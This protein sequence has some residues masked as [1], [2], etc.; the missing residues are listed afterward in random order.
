MTE[1]VEDAV[2][3]VLGRHDLVPDGGPP[4]ASD[5][6]RIVVLGTGWGAAAF[7]KGIDT[8]RFDVTVVS[9]RN[10]FVFTPMLAGASGRWTIGPSQN[11]SGR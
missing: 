2:E 3:G 9:P 1:I 10:Y 6:E 5:R 4:A 11:R 7:L 8:G